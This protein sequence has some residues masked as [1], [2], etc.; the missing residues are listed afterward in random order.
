MKA[1]FREKYENSIRPSLLEMFDYKNIFA[2][3][4]IDKI[5]INMGVGEAVKDSKKVE[6]A[7]RDLTYISGQKP[8]ITRAKKANATFKLRAN[9]AIGCKV[10]LRSERMYEFI[11]RLI[12]IALPRVRD[13][14]GL[15]SKSFDGKGNFAF[16]IKEQI[17]F[18]E[19]EYDKVDE[20]RG[21]DII[22]STTAI[23]DKEGFELLKGFNFP[24]SNSLKK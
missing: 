19:I 1:H 21:M 2:V 3:P 23:S 11:D 8:I 20:I 6:N 16:G 22:V 12:T 17:V 5:V 7:V 10:T 14:R 4:R 9:M 24:F 18:P 13:F 15:N